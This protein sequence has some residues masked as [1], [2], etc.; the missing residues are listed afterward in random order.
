MKKTIIVTESELK[1]MISE[2]VKAI[3]N[4]TGAVGAFFNRNFKGKEFNNQA[5]VLD[6][7]IAKY[8]KL[9]SQHKQEIQQ[10][11]GSF[12]QRYQESLN[13]L[14]YFANQMR[15]GYPVEQS[16]IANWTKTMD[17]ILR[18]IGAMTAYNAKQ[19][20]MAK[21]QQQQYQK[22]RYDYSRADNYDTG[23]GVSHFGNG[24][25]WRA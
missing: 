12:L 18:T 14:T 7:T 25:A 4:E 20:E 1:E 3:L 6:K 10:Q 13:K 23:E 5:A 2:S 11:G 22:N 16:T 21:Q 19:A 24:D 8:Q 17:R 9:F 15:N